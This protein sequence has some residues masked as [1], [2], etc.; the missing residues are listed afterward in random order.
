MTLEIDPVGG[1]ITRWSCGR[2]ELMRPRAESAIGPME[3]ACFPLVPYANRI[4]Q[5]QFRF[6]GRDVTI[7]PNLTAQRH[8]L[9]GEG[10]L[11]TWQVKTLSDTRIELELHG[12]GGEWPWP[13]AA[14]QTILLDE[15]GLTLRL[16]I[17]NLSASASPIGFGIH[18]YF[19]NAG[20][21]RLTANV[22]GVWLTDAEF[23]PT[24]QAEGAR[25]ADWR[26]GA[27]VRGAE[28]IDHCYSGW[29][30]RAEISLSPNG[31]LIRMTADEALGF[32]HIYAPPGEAFF[33]V[34]PVSHRPDALNAADPQAAGIRVL[35]PKERIE[36]EVRF[37]VEW[38][39]I[40]GDD[41]NRHG[42]R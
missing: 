12:G 13:Y 22:T 42:D 23:L 24:V 20:Q 14:E 31:P 39:N 29:D 5:G 3:A 16:G 9:H 37:D 26:A 27:A 34:E 32:L 11:A 40:V 18:P 33:C 21:A 36:S 17:Q 38:P 41:L 10:W 4:A 19:P 28:L 35:A 1:S 25:F 8:P 30:G 15:K 2:A 6:G 7:A